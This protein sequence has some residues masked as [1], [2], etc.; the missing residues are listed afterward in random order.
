MLLSCPFRT[1]LISI[2]EPNQSLPP[3]LGVESR[4]TFIIVWVSVGLPPV[5][6]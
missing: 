5:P 4:E 6:D 1:D 3:L 2:L